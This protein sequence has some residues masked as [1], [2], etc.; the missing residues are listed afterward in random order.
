MVSISN[1][2]VKYVRKLFVINCQYH[3]FLGWKSFCQL[4]QQWHL[5]FLKNHLN[6][7]E[8]YF[9]FQC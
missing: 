2:W 5:S 7:F 3:S 4:S 9:S 8:I 6:D 1:H